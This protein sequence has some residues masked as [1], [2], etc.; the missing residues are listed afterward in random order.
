MTTSKSS[1]S[2]SGGGSILRASALMASGTM[3]SRILG[4]V[5][6]ALLLAVIGTAAGGVNAAFQTANTL[7]NMVFNILAS[8]VLDAILVPQIV[9][10]LKTRHQGQQYV[11]RLLT[12]AG[13]LLFGITVVAMIAA[14][15]LVIITSAGYDAQ[16]RSLA[17]A[18]ALLCLPQIFFYGLYNLLGELLNARGVFGPYMWAPVV[19][20]V[21][22]IAG[23]G[24][25]LALWGTSPTRFDVSDLTAPQF[26]LLGGSATL[27]VI[28]Q[29]A[30]LLIPMK[31]A[32]IAL[33]P[34][35]HFKGTNFGS[36][37]KVAGWTFATLGVSQ[38]GVISSNNLAAL[39][40]AWG[41]E[42][43]TYVVGISAM[44]TAFMIYMVPQSLVSVSLATAVF[45][46]ISSAVVDKDEPGV[47]HWFHLGV[48][49]TNVLTM[50]FAAALAAGSVPIMQT[51]AL[52]TTE[53]ELV[54]SY[55]WV[56]LAYLPGLSAMG[57]L[58][59]TQR[60]FYAYEDAKP[61]FLSVI[62][63][64]VLQILVGWTIYFLTDAHWWVVGAAF[65]E[66]VC[67]I[68][69]AY[70]GLRMVAR[71][72]RHI[73][74]P[75]IVRT[76]LTYW[77]T[78]V[79][80][81][82]VG[83]V[84]MWLVGIDTV[85]NS[86]LT[87]LL[88]SLVKV[89]FVCSFTM[90]IYLVALRAISP[91]E[92][93]RTVWPLLARLRLPA[94]LLSV[95]A[96][97]PA[98][99]RTAQDGDRQALP[100]DREAS[101]QVIMDRTASTEGMEGAMDPE[102]SEDAVPTTGAFDPS[103]PDTTSGASWLE[104]DDQ[105]AITR[106]TRV[107]EPEPIEEPEVRNS[108]EP[109]TGAL[110]TSWITLDEETST[111]QT[112]ATQEAPPALVEGDFVWTPPEN[113]TVS[114]RLHE[115]PATI[116][117]GDVLG[118]PTG[119][120]GIADGDVHDDPEATAVRGA[121]VADE[122]TVVRSAPEDEDP[123]ATAVRGAFVADEATVVRSAPEDE[124][125]P[126]ATK[127]AG[128]RVVDKSTI[129]R[130]IP[131]IPA[132][133]ATPGVTEAADLPDPAD[134]ATAIRTAP[135][136]AT[137]VRTSAEEATA[138]RTT[139]TFAPTGA[140][141]GAAFG[142]VGTGDQDG[143]QRWW[144]FDP[145]I[146]SFVVAG[147]LVI[148]GGIWALNTAFAPLGPGSDLGFAAAPD[149]AQSQ[150]SGQSEQSAVADPAPAP[151]PAHAPQISSAQVFS[152]DGSGDHEDEAINLIDGR[153]ETQWHSRWFDDNRFT[154]D[155]TVTVL[156]KLKE[157]TKVSQIT[158]AMDPTTSGGELV[159]RSVNPDTPRQG[160]ELAKTALSPTTT[161]SLPQP[162][163][164]DAISL[165]F[166]TMPTSQDGKAWAWISEITVK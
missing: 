38:F 10:A 122:A 103:H 54:R 98:T 151:A 142:T 158:L 21:V 140:A 143:E 11:N 40:D 112:S 68:S 141:A 150:Q 161:I 7:P 94:P 13:T 70:I 137:V 25:F 3:V 37:S 26:W 153:P 144:L 164:T 35:F 147:G 60:V 29:A 44:A 154:D 4:F 57:I 129:V 20:N 9:T 66:T 59:M 116:D 61:I 136:D 100:V 99:R 119:L 115:P 56:L 2:S 148:V 14:P 31:R 157:K 89:T 5:R 72:N 33:R 75:R 162:V 55:A 64:N 50:L 79:I 146:P 127:I 1:A 69:Q 71:R 18:F 152:W 155:N 48:R 145:T 58:L 130:S 32:G 87:R 53:P 65:A 51:V 96:V 49:S 84:L 43:G 128:L 124:D 12:L 15:L 78:A 77:A 92:S 63:P 8:G 135:D 45:T 105:T 73:D 125:D 121:F 62:I 6:N 117:E 17:I 47:A 95:L 102:Q 86:T 93:A 120:P 16:I 74:V 52:T 104:D 30:F 165:S 28:C 139:A 132:A 109:F 131:L 34:D 83:F 24:V 41:H 97:D 46:R 160:T 19:N 80:A 39:A 23:L 107:P 126:N 114:T 42:H 138:I 85:T 118:P 90:V 81:V 134:E 123:E 67:R 82:A 27:G 88:V 36:A 22:G 111:S 76:Y 108:S 110:D 149:V 106:A 91:A 113:E 166:R 101:D 133:S 159:V 163:E 156:L